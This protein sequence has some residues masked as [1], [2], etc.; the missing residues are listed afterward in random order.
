MFSKDISKNSISVMAV[1]G[2]AIISAYQMFETLGAEWTASFSAWAE[3]RRLFPFFSSELFVA[4]F[5]FWAAGRAGDLIANQILWSLKTGCR[6]WIAYLHWGSFGF[7]TVPC[8]S[9]END[10]FIS[11]RN[12][13]FFI[14]RRFTASASL[15]L[16]CSGHVCLSS[17]EVHICYLPQ[18]PSSFFI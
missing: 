4:H 12:C 13:C 7:P 16:M 18:F 6:I 3:W 9:S 10:S 17:A 14:F 11:Y 15:G 1:F 2:G 8:Y 5:L